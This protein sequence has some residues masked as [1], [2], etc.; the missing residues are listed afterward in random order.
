SPPRL[1]NRARPP[2]RTAIPT[3]EPRPNRVCS[4]SQTNEV[5]RARRLLRR[6]RVANGAGAS[7]PSM[8]SAG[9]KRLKAKYASTVK[10]NATTPVRRTPTR[11]YYLSSR[12]D[13]RWSKPRHF[14][15]RPLG[16]KGQNK[17]AQRRRQYASNND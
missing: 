14:P 12:P 7:S 11:Q 5:M 6:R 15:A 4:Q 17:R 2:R 13:E 10:G 8:S 9:S 16:M 3:H 1:A